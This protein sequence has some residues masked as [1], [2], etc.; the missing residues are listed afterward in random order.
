M[1]NKKILAGILIFTMILTASCSEKENANNKSDITESA[2][3]TTVETTE[4][5]NTEEPFVF[6]MSD[7]DN[8]DE[9]SDFEYNFNFDSQEDSMTEEDPTNDEE[10]KKVQELIAEYEK[11]VKS[12]D[13]EAMLKI[14]DI[15][16]LNYISEG[17]EATD[18][19]LLSVLNNNDDPD[20]IVITA[21]YSEMTFEEPRCYNSFSKEYNDFLSDEMLSTLS[22]VPN[23]AS[24]K[25]KIDG[26]YM[27][28]MT[29]ASDSQSEM[30][31]SSDMD[32]YVFRIN[33]EWKVDIGY[34]FIVDM[35][36]AFSSMNI[37]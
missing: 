28:R 34:G 7:E 19:E 16:M 32:M 5:D 17:K 15:D 31:F 1:K 11:A 14:T 37:E 2:N 29:S 27:F 13:Y 10:L 25:Y 18:D 3:V 24:S 26:L 36:K 9:I 4:F 12:N 33:G 6:E 21:D 35:Y 22:D 30:N 8:D 23:D 20:S